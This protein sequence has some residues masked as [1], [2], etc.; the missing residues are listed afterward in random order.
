MLVPFILA[1]FLAQSNADDFA[2]SLSEVEIRD[3]INKQ[4]KVESWQEG[5]DESNYNNMFTVRLDSTDGK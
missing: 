4:M 1:I 2:D 3:C 5:K